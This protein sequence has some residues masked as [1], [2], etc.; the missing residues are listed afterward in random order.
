MRELTNPHDL[1]QMCS[2]HLKTGSFHFKQVKQE[3]SVD[4]QQKEAHKSALS[5]LPGAA[6]KAGSLSK[7]MMEHSKVRVLIL[8]ALGYF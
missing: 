6:D 5:P 2:L 3:S 8:R 4:D 1:K 7:F